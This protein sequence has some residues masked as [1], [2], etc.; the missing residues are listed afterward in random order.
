MP[1]KANRIPVNSEN[2]KPLLFE[3]NTFSAHPRP[4]LPT[5]ILIS[6]KETRSCC[7]CIKVSS[8]GA[9][10]S[11]VLR[12]AKQLIPK[13][14]VALQNW[15][16]PATSSLNPVQM[17]GF[18]RHRGSAVLFSIILT[19][20]IYSYQLFRRGSKS[21]LNTPLQNNWAMEKVA[22]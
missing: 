15:H 16:A 18:Y 22:S 2:T 20:N 21:P 10:K 7:S 11:A 4:P 19:L 5:G 3:K 6:C 17:H 12:Q 14:Y 8:W 9:G 13:L 1:N